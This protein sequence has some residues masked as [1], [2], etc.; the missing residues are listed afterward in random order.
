MNP[1]LYL[2]GPGKFYTQYQLFL[3]MLHEIKQISLNCEVFSQRLR[4]LPNKYEKLI[5]TLE[6]DNKVFSLIK[7]GH[8][9]LQIIAFRIIN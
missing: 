4:S 3:Q 1:E 9:I 7:S 2:R 6:T 8:K 5:L